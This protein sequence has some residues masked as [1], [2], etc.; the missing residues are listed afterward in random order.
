[1]SGP[2]GRRRDG[3]GAG[4]RD[5]DGVRDRGAAALGLCD[6]SLS[7]DEF[8]VLPQ[9]T[10]F[11]GVDAAGAVADLCVT[12]AVVVRGAGVSVP[13]PMCQSTSLP[14]SSQWTLPLRNG[15]TIATVTPANSPP[16]IFMTARP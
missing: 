16:R 1:M 11:L 12:P 6:Q 13:W 7:Q 14:S 8:F 15:V 9:A 5:E 4:V 10:E 3:R 2:A